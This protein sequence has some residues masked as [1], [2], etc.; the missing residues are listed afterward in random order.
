[1]ECTIH[2]YTHD[3]RKILPFKTIENPY[4]LSLKYARN[5]HQTN[6]LISNILYTTNNFKAFDYI[7]HEFLYHIFINMGIDGDPYYSINQ[8][9]N[10]PVSCVQLNGHL[11]DWLHITPFVQQG[12]SLSPT[13][14]ACYINDQA[15]EIEQS[16][17]GVNVGGNN[18]GIWLYADGIALI[19]TSAENIARTPGH[20]EFAQFSMRWAFGAEIPWGR[21]LSGFSPW[22]LT[23]LGPAN[24]QWPGDLVF[25]PW[26]TDDE[27]IHSIFHERALP[28]QLGPSSWG[29][30][31]IPH[32]AYST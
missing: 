27:F 3:L 9:D 24:L 2:L 29:I 7:K 6:P 30:W 25:I 20:W 22:R 4:L 8:V 17:T 11:T 18:F 14:F 1:M 15:E 10:H 26:I 13:L 16:N 23:K 19:A 5:P 32:T 12:D 21:R 31:T 28:D